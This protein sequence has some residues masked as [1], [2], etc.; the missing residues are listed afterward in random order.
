MGVMVAIRMVDAPC[1]CNNTR[2]AF[3]VFFFARA[4]MMNGGSVAVQQDSH[5]AAS[6]QMWGLWKST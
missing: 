3:I 2:G 6:P 1:R 5:F 4:P